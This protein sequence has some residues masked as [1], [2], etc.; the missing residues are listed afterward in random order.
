MKTLENEALMRICRKDLT[1]SPCPAIG[2]WEKRISDLERK[3]I[4]KDVIFAE[5]DEALQKY[6]YSL[7]KKPDIGSWLPYKDYV[8][9]KGKIIGI[10]KQSVF[11]FWE[12]RLETGETV[13]VH[14]LSMEVDDIYLSGLYLVDDY[15]EAKEKMGKVIWINQNGWRQ[16][17]LTEDRNVSYPVEHLEKVKVLDVST[18]HLGHSSG[19]QPFFLTVQKSDGEVG[20]IGYNS[21]N[22]FDNNPIDPSWAKSI[23]ETIKKQKIQLG[24]TKK[25]VLLSWGGPKDINRTVT[26]QG[27]TEQ[28]VYSKR[29]LLYFEDEKLTA[30]Q[31]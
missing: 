2:D 25:Q 16:P 11:S 31:D 27:T 22:F 26:L 18:K 7:Y 19:I 17:L 28:W 30:F 10:V 4:G 20:F 24:M 3:Q 6:G 12:L 23:V 21:K 1:L 8:G 5:K 9:K 15:L 29:R 13:Y 14:K